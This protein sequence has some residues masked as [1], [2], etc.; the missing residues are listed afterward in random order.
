[1]SGGRFDYNQY[2]IREIAEDIQQTIDKNGLKL[3]DDLI[4]EN[5]KWYGDDYYERFP[6]ELYHYKYPL[7]V[8]EKF[9]EAVVILKKAEIYAQRIDWLLSNDDSEE[10]FFK[11]LEEDLKEIESESTN[12]TWEDIEK[13]YLKEEYPVFGGPFTDALTPFEWLKKYFNSPKRK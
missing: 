2:R 10:S 8:I 12:Q 1:M 9:K 4:K 11:R 13:D 6:E 7:E 3:D 5:K